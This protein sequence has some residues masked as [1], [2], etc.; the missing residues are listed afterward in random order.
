MAVVDPDFSTLFADECLWDCETETRL[1]GIEAALL[2][3][4]ITRPRINVLAADEAEDEAVRA[5]AATRLAGR[6]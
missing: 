6:S 1:V 5:A 4:R 3:D 2:D